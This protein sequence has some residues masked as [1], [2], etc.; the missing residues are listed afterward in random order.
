MDSA[1]SSI[2]EKSERDKSSVEDLLFLHHRSLGYPSLSLL[3]RLYPRLFEK[4]KKDNFFCDACELEKHTR[5]S[6]VSSGNM[7]SCVFELYI[8]MY[9]VLIQ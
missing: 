1:L 8:L 4:A 5:G 7:S 9:G 2:V 6:Y 3:S